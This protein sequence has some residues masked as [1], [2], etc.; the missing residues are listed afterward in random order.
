MLHFEEKNIKIVI[1][2]V[3]QQVQISLQLGSEGE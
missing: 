1:F 3:K 2:P